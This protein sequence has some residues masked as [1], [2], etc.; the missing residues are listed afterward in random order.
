MRRTLFVAGLSLLLLSGCISVERSPVVEG[1]SCGDGTVLHG[2][3]CIGVLRKVYGPVCGEG[4]V[5]RGHECVPV[6]STKVEEIPVVSPAQVQQS[7]AVSPAALHVSQTRL[8]PTDAHIRQSI[9]A[10]SLR[11]YPGNCP[12]PYSSASNGSRCGGRSAYSRPGGYEPFCYAQDVPQVM[13]ERYRQR[14]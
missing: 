6:T 8:I 9:M 13:V 3:E 2:D 10:E 4:T 7:P 1:Y 5:H 14:L 11:G 12:C